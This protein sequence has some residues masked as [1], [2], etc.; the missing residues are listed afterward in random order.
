MSP[1]ATIGFWAIV[2][3]GSHLLISSAAIR[4]R[5]IAAVGAQPYTGLYSLIALGT[6][7][8]LAVA[9]G[10]NKHAGPLIWNLRGADVVRGL[11]IVMMFAALILL[12]AGL[13]NPSPSTLGAR[14][15]REVSGILKITRHPAFV[16]IALFAIAHL[17]M[18]GWL[19]DIIFFGS[20]AALA[21][22]GGF[23][24]DRRKLRELGT[25]YRTFFDHTSFFPGAALISGRQKCAMGDL[26]WTAIAGGIALAFI[27]LMLHP[28]LFGG[29]PLG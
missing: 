9:F 19:G 24:Q 16:A 14:P 28:R 2:F 10:H 12:V 15:R 3:V 6:F 8:P 5:L 7:I 21:I 18:N 25:S 13:I 11:T 17:L 20:L 1:V 23:D 22:V 27:V 4:P 26:P 29:S